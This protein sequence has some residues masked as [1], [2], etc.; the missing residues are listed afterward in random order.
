MEKQDK[1][2]GSLGL[3]DKL[4]V[5]TIEGIIDFQIDV[6]EN[7]EALY[8]NRKGKIKIYFHSG[9]FVIAS[10]FNTVANSD[11]YENICVNKTKAIQIQQEMRKDRLLEL[12]EKIY[13][14]FKELNEYLKKY[15]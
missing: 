12:Q 15:F 6:I 1:T 11:H 5:P 14:D 9:H 10:P 2:F 13:D 3:L 7:Y 8:G 4:Y